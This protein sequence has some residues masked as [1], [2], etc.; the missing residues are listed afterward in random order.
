MGSRR[1]S[2][3]LKYLSSYLCVIHRQEEKRDY[4]DKSGYDYDKGYKEHGYDNDR[5]HYNDSRHHRFLYNVF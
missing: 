5:G 3:C 1:R 4:N 2:P